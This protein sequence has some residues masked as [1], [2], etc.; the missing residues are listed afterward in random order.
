MPLFFK[1][2][3]SIKIDIVMKGKQIPIVIICLDGHENR[4]FNS[5]KEAEM[6]I[7]VDRRAIMK[8]LRS[9]SGILPGKQMYVDYACSD[10][11]VE[12]YELKGDDRL[13]YG[14]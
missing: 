4:F 10:Y 1:N 8:A 7:G 9:E 11:D 13:G 3:D 6:Y 5:A 2:A 12:K 14:N